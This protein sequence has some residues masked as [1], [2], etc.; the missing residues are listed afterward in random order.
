MPTGAGAYALPVGNG[1]AAAVGVGDP[2][3]ATPGV[4]GCVEVA[5]GSGW[6]PVAVGLG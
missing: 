2:V 3:G 5:V 4:A 1:E 6:A